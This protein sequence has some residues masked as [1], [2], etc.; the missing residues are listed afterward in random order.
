MNRLGNV[1][2]IIVVDISI[3]VIV[4]VEHGNGN[5]AMVIDAGLAAL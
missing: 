4:P 3:V 1:D 2:V 5:V